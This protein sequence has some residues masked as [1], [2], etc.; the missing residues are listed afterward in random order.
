L[1]MTILACDERRPSRE[2]QGE[3]ER[4]GEESRTEQMT[5]L[6]CAERWND[7]TKRRTPD[8]YSIDR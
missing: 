7:A 6:Y 5:V 4:R 3:E 2:R 8:R 1:V